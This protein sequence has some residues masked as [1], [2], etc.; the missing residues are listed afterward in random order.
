V[1]ASRYHVQ[2]TALRCGLMHLRGSPPSIKEFCADDD[3]KLLLPIEFRE[4]RRS[5]LEAV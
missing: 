5:K 1:I 3:G 4:F 2:I